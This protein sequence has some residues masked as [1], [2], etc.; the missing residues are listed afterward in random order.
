[1]KKTK[2]I[3]IV[4]IVLMLSLTTTSYADWI[5][6]HPNGTKYTL[7][8]DIPAEKTFGSNTYKLNFDILRDKHLVVYGDH[9]DVSGNEKKSTDVSG[10]EW[11]YLGLTMY[12]D[13]FTNKD[14]PND[15]DS[16]RKPWE[17]NWIRNPWGMGLCKSSKFNRD[18]DATK[19]IETLGWGMRGE[20]L[21]DF[22]VI[23]IKPT[24]YAP[25]S[26]KGFHKT[27]KGVVYYQT[28]YLDPLE[29]VPEPK[30]METSV[31]ADFYL[32]P[33]TYEYYDTRFSDHS[34]ASPGSNIIKW[35]LKIDGNNGYTKTFTKK[36]EAENELSKGLREGKYTFILFV[37]ND[38]GKSDQASQN[39]KVKKEGEITEIIVKPMITAPEKVKVNNVFTVK[40][41]KNSILHVINK[42]E[43][44]H[45]Y[46]YESDKKVNPGELTQEN[47]TYRPEYD[48]KMEFEISFD[49]NKYVYFIVKVG[50]RE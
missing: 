17:K 34:K 5:Y 30:P 22:F 46:I 18:P 47:F 48:D 15:A 21:I 27:D 6:T 9:T 25:G 19:W 26:A 3:C 43:Y 13:K 45:W 35:E 24:K 1:M 38:Y 41:V 39:I 36:K 11:R 14:F 28:F 49:K 12:G 31:K 40:I 42:L 33:E 20:E 2:T 8:D 37:E 50:Y 10:D 32:I 23:Q 7:P 44:I 29:E 4:I 16:G